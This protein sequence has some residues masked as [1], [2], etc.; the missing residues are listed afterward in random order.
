M[1]KKILYIEDD[2]IN[3][4]LVKKL[5]TSKGYEVHEAENG[6]EGVSQSEA[7]QP[8]LI[9]MDMQMPGLDGYEATKQIK[10]KPGLG[11]IPIIALTAHA[12]HDEKEKCMAA[13]CDGFIPKPIDV[14]KFPDQI[15]QF[16]LEFPAFPSPA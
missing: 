1:S 15:A 7:V 10:A 12:L 5:L 2:P 14:L 13:G 6:N 9:L 4:Y 8:H 16:L 3:R 11:N